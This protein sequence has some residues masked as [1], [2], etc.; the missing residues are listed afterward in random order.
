MQAQ[1]GR[2]GSKGIALLTP[3]LGSRW[4]W[5]V[6]VM[7]QLLYPLEGAL[8]PTGEEDD[9]APGLV[10]KGMENRKSHAPTRFEPRIFQPVSSCYND[11]LILA[12]TLLCNLDKLLKLVMLASV[13][14]ILCCVCTEIF[15]K[16]F[17]SVLN[18]SQ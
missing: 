15:N 16:R 12:P 5:L 6:N 11:C 9:W 18:T 3:N 10:W 17:H 2:R 14:S 13:F 1:K 7:H 8:L 4:E